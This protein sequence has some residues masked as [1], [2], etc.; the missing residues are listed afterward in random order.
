MRSVQCRSP[1][2]DGPWFPRGPPGG[3]AAPPPP[4][5]VGHIIQSHGSSGMLHIELNRLGSTLH[6]CP[7]WP[8]PLRQTLA[9]QRLH[10]GR[11]AQHREAA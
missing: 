11:Q 8:G 9:A 6:L 5:A 7:S 2:A 3:G 1:A 4:G 10:P